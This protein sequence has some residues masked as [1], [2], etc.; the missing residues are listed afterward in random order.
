MKLTHILVHGLLTAGLVISFAGCAA[1]TGSG[2]TAT[3][4]PT[5][6]PTPTAAAYPMPD[7]GP[8]PAPAVLT[9]EGIEQLRLESVEAQWTRVLVRYPGAARPET[10]F[11]GYL[12]GDA[13]LQAMRDCL[14]THNVTISESR[15]GWEADAPIVSVGPDAQNQEEAVGGFI[16]MTMYPFTPVPAPTDAQLGYIYDYLTQFIVPCYQAN[17]VARA[18]DAAAPT[19]EFFIA[20]WPNQ[21][22][23]PSPDIAMVDSPEWDAVNDACPPTK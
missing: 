9:E 16:C 8:S 19:R 10:Q 5:P 7:L 13:R 22:W 6:T 3:P 14:E 17:G 2:T 23:F 15:S 12:A 21:N 1:S 20:N 4:E 18:D 11:A